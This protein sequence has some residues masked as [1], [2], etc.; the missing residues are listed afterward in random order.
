MLRARSS[1]RR[2]GHGFLSGAGGTIDGDGSAF[3]STGPDAGGTVGHYARAMDK[4]H[5]STVIT[6]TID[7]H[8]HVAI[9]ATGLATAVVTPVQQTFE[10]FS[11]GRFQLVN[12]LGR[13]RFLGDGLR[14]RV[15][16]FGLHRAGKRVQV[17]ENVYQ[18]SHV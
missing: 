14:K 17:Q 3:I 8:D 5:S 15:C 2:R 9:F 7:L 12:A 6:W 1:G 16:A 13:R 11:F 18:P 4:C 10:I